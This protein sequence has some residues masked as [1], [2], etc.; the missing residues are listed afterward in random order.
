MK[1]LS[2]MQPWASL[3]LG[4]FKKYETRSWKTSYRGPLLIHASKRLPL[5]NA[6][7]VLKEPFLSTLDRMGYKNPKDLPIGMILGRVHLDD[8][9]PTS[10]LLEKHMIQELEYSFGDYSPGRYGWLVTNPT[11]LVVPLEYTGK[12]GLFDVPDDLLD[13]NFLKICTRNAHNG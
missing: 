10:E 3:I 9:I 8:C 12:L 2:V 1:C 5:Y 7:L 13:G 11:P 4:G 6:D